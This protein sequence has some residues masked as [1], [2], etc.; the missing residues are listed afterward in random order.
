MSDNSGVV[1]GRVWKFGDNINTDL[2]F[3]NTAFHLEQA[4]QYKLV[5]S[6]N[7]PGWVDQVR[8]GDLLIAGSN[9]GYGSGRPVGKVLAECGIRGVIAESINGLC[10]RSC[11]SGGMLAMGC[12]GILDLFEEGDMGRFNYRTGVIE[13]LTQKTS[14]TAA[15]MPQ[16]LLDTVRA[17]GLLQM[18]IAEG[19]V[20]RDPTYPGNR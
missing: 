2:I 5:F 11:V 20:E 15:P 6:A 1:T 4:E 16:L 8:V 14:I 13:N 12:R 19:F 10:L 7:R 18:L 3:P 17:G 9:F